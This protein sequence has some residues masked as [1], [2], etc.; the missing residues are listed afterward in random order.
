MGRLSFLSLV[1]YFLVVPSVL[2]Q[3]A[4]ERDGAPLDTTPDAPTGGPAIVFDGND[5]F[6]DDVL[7]GA[8]ARELRG[9]RRG[10][11][12]PAD[13]VDAAY[14]IETW[15][16]DQGFPDANVRVRMVNELP[17]AP[18]QTVADVDD[19]G[20]VDRVDFLVAEGQRLYLGRVEF[21]GNNA[22]ADAVLEQ[23]VPRRGGAILGAGRPLFRPGDVGTITDNVRLHYLLAGYLRVRLEEPRT[24]RD[25]NQVN[26]TITIEE[27]RLYT[28]ETIRIEG[29][30]ELSES[31]AQEVGRAAPETG[32]PYTER[33]ASDGANAI[34]RLLGQHGYLTDV[35]YELVPDDEE[36]TV[37]VRYRFDP[38]DRAYL[39]SIRV[40]AAG[41]E[42]L[43]V[44]PAIVRH[45]FPLAPGEPIDLTL[46]NEGRQRLYQTGL[47]RV[48]STE[49]REAGGD[50]ASAETTPDG[51][52]VDLVVTLEED[53]NRYVELAAGWSSVEQILGSIEYVDRN[54]LGTGRLW[55]VEASGSL[56]GYRFSTRV[57]DR[58]VLGL[59]S[60]LSFRIEHAYRI[61]EAFRDRSTAADLRAEIRL[62]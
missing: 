59:G 16:A 42:P 32:V 23:Y 13:L 30:D 5:T 36:A 18:D 48:V 51:R 56:R 22:F 37:A 25:G 38:G 45:R 58:I 44:M 31:L 14:T 19:F 9:I 39:G 10:E 7:L 2:A 43:R 35:R 54:V 53:R 61:R 27:G 15:Y 4:G 17:G 60:L 33:R 11:G 49:L 50:D 34:E 62:A 57:V 12:S 46:V 6:T 1:A 20:M 41:D 28:I 47:F 24:T 21:E 40:E 55:G 3:D 8:A 26:V 29:I 52:V